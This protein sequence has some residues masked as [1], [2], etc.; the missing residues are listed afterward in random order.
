MGDLFRFVFVLLFLGLLIFLG[1]T[2][3]LSLGGINPNLALI[4]FSG[5]LLEPYFKKRIKPGFLYILL[6]FAFEVTLILSDFW[7]LPWAILLL[8][9]LAIFFLRNFFTGRSF[10]DFLL[11]VGLGTV[12]FY[13]AL[14]FT[15]GSVF[16][17]GFVFGEVVYNLVLGSI[18]WLCLNFFGKY[19]YLHES[20]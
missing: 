6:F 10:Q 9:I 16:A 11:A 19:G 20:R 1:M 3:I 18:F 7:M 8:I 17:G 4:F 14:K 13:G 2:R 15:A 5:L 12:I